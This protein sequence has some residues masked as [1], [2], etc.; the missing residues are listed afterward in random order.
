[1]WSAFGASLIIPAYL[2]QRRGLSPVAWII[3]PHGIDSIDLFA[4]L[5]SLIIA[6]DVWRRRSTAWVRAEVL[7]ALREVLDGD[8]RR[9]PDP[10]KRDLGKPERPKRPRAV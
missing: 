6:L 10:R 3:H 5:F 7:D 2:S 8:R 9:R 4:G 1:L